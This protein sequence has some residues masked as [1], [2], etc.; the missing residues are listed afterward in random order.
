MAYLVTFKETDPLYAID[1]STPTAPV[2]L[3]ALK[4][5]GFSSYLH[6]L[7][8]TELLGVGKMTQM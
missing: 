2:V 4:V 3:D 8:S 5:P 6:P 7:G 1:L